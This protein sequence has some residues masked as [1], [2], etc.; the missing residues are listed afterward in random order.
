MLQVDAPRPAR[1]HA[2]AREDGPSGRR[3]QPAERAAPRTAPLRIPPLS[4]DGKVR[5]SCPAGGQVR[6]PVDL[7][8]MMEGV[9][10]RREK[11]KNDVPLAGEKEE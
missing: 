3:A 6:P 4:H 11:R 7:R 8:G 2:T 1:P 5:T 10:R 9:K